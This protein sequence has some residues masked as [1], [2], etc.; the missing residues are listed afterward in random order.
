MPKSC[1]EAVPVL[2]WLAKCDRPGPQVDCESS[3]SGAAVQSDSLT[4]W[5]IDIIQ[6]EMDI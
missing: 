4:I 6:Q 2:C 5:S 1:V 3:K